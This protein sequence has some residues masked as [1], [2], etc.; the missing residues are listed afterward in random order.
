MADL[1]T[2][3][4]PV[5]RGRRRD[6]DHLRWS[7][8]SLR[9]LPHSNV[10]IVGQLPDWIDPATVSHIP[11]D[12]GRHKFVNIGM[13][14]QAALDSADVTDRFV[15]FNDDFYV[16]R[17]VDCVELHDRGPMGP[18]CEKLRVA[19]H[20]QA[21]YSTEHRE[22]LAGMASQRSI[23]LEWGYT[24]DLPFCDLHCPIPIDKDR[25]R[26]VL[27]RTIDT[28]PDHQLGHFRGLY[29]AGLPS[30]Y[31][32]DSKTKSRNRHYKL[33]DHPDPY[34]STYV[35]TWLGPVGAQIREMFPDPSP[36]ERNR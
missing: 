1:P 33:S 31:L 35:R 27:A 18:F 34:F 3:V 10:V 24:D 25:C 28:K 17:P 7:I 13:N 22:Y 6:P 12:Q 19:K 32:E 21:S 29:G 26:D 4:Y 9:N 16:L 23:L 15:W 36:Y 8:R 11:T 5:R 14:L 30:T 2:V 20:Y